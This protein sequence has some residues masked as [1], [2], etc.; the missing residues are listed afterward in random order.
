MVR[1]GRYSSGSHSWATLNGSEPT[2]SAEATLSMPTPLAS[3]LRALRS[4][5]GSPTGRVSYPLRR[6]KACSLLVSGTQKA[7]TQCVSSPS[8]NAD[9][10][11]EPFWI[12]LKVRA[13]AIIDDLT[14]IHHDSARR[15]VER[16]PRILLDDD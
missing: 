1:I 8:S 6:R 11:I 4:I 16:E 3:I 7:H 2:P 12:I 15:D 13:F 9:Q 14:P 10:L 5:A